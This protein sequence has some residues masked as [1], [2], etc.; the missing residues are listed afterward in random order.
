MPCDDAEPLLMSFNQ[1]GTQQDLLPL[2][3]P[4]QVSLSLL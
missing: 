4:K 3:I 2:Q 1:E